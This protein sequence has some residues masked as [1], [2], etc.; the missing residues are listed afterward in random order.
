MSIRYLV[1]VILMVGFLITAGAWAATPKTIKFAVNSPG[2]VPLL[3]FDPN[4]QTYAGVVAD[5][6]NGLA[7]QGLITIEFVDSNQTRSEQYVIDGKVDLML[8]N[9]AW[10]PQSAKMIVSE[11]IMEYSTFLYSLQ[12]FPAEFSLTTIKQ[13]RICTHQDFTYPG[14]EPYLD[15]QQLY[16]IDSGNHAAMLSMLE[17]QRCDYVV[18]NDYNAA[19]A[20]AALEFCHLTLYQSPVATSTLDLHFVMRP[21]LSELKTFIDQQ[22]L[23]FIKSGQFYNSLRAHASEPEFAQPSSCP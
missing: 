21:A 7:E 4:T 23:R 5:F 16:R 12:P 15:Q 9:P 1:V 22:L 10:L 18:M 19:Q 2:S 3:Y 8:A 11:P 14:L 6:F 13:K 17:K 20:F